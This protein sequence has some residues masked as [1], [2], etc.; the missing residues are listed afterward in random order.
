MWRILIVEDD[1]IIAR[2][3]AEHLSQ[4]GYDTCVI[5][6]FEHVL[7][8]FGSFNPQLVLMDI[9]LPFYNGYHWCSKIRNISSVPVIFLSSMSDNMNIVM[10]MNMGGDDFITKPFDLNVLT[11]K[12]QAMLRRTYSFDNETH[13]I[14]CRGGILNINNQTFFYGDNKIELTRNEYKIL[15]CLMEKKGSAVERETIIEKLWESDDFVDDNT[16][17]VN[18]TRLRKKLEN[19]GLKDYIQTRKGIGYIIED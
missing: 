3:I 11:A 7:D 14:E 9:S 18:I 6:D 13:I 12:I 1:E 17:T 2:T 15:Q 4:W 16:L 5:K 19:T 10:A 8:E